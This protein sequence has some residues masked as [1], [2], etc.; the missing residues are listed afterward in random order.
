MCFAWCDWCIGRATWA[1]NINSPGCFSKIQMESLPVKLG[2]FSISMMEILWPIP[3]MYGI[4]AYTWLFFMVHVGKY[5]MHGWYGWWTNSFLI[6]RAFFIAPKLSKAAAPAP[7]L[8]R[9]RRRQRHPTGSFFLV[10]YGLMGRETGD[11]WNPRKKVALKKEHVKNKKKKKKKKTCKKNNK[12][13]NNNNWLEELRY[14]LQRFII[15]QLQKTYLYIYTG[16]WFHSLFNH[17]TPQKKC[18]SCPPF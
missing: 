11:G 14:R 5:T 17:V 6:E 8:A 13:K 7:T 18:W 4:F 10:A 3:S 12:N 15:T 9:K 16:L 2:L 1:T